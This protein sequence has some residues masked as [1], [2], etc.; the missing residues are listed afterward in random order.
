M[1]IS[2]QALYERVWAAPLRKIAPEFGVSDVG[3]AKACR[4]HAIPLP[5]RGHWIR[6]EHGKTSERPALPPSSHGDTISLSLEQS[7]AQ[8]VSM[9]SPALTGL[10][11]QVSSG[12][13]PLAPFA[14]ATL[15]ALMKARPSSSGLALCGGKAH[16]KCALSPALFARACRI[17]D[18]IERKLP[19]VGG[20][21]MRGVDERPLC[22]SFRGQAVTFS[23]AERYTR[24]EFIPESERKS[25][26]PRKEYLYTLTGELKLAVDGYFDGRKSW[27]D[28]ARAKL[29]DKLSE[30]LAGLAAAAGAMKRVAEERA[31]QSRLWEEQARVRREREEQARR[32]EAFR[33]SFA[34][35][36]DAWYRHQA[37]AEYL[38]HLRQAVANKQLTEASA[39][40]LSLAAQAVADLNP[41]PSR[42]RLIHEGAKLE[43][44]AGPFGPKVTAERRVQPW[45]YR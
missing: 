17:L 5:P 24:S 38:A 41:A 14:Q 3:L 2:R 1:K 22:V 20:E 9:V 33:D 10:R 8:R 43:S 25:A 19:E 21:L 6:V 35:E 45:D 23:L 7:R 29:E 18:A 44:W 40:W 36:A 11:V 37:A 32:R 42:L 39:E 4:R 13:A 34:S 15:T 27:S 30:V 16:F 26:Y 31:E 12:T 28:G